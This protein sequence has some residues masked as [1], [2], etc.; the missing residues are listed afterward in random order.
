M[1]LQRPSREFERRAMVE[2]QLL[3]RSVTDQRVLDAMAAVPR[4]EFIPEH[5]QGQAYQDHPVAIGS[6]QTIS[7]PYMVAL[8]T[9]LLELHPEDRVL[10]IGT[11]SGYQTAVLANLAREVVSIERHGEL[12]ESAHR[13]LRRLGY[14]NIRIF[15]GDG[16]LGCLEFAPYD[17]IMVTAGG[18]QVPE[19]LKEQLAVGGRLLC[20]AGNRSVQRLLKIVRGRHGFREV[21]SINCTFVPL[22]GAEGWPEEPETD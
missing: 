19:S 1:T 5:L 11:G 17:A 6:G 22:V 10:E 7:Q 15:R 16:T 12:A 13:T 8:M 3:A 21:E 18:P 14:R 20:P 2:E 9:Q 4:H